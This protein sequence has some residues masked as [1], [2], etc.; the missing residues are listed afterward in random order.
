MSNNIIVW[1]ELWKQQ[2][3]WLFITNREHFKIERKA[4]PIDLINW[5]NASKQITF[6]SSI[7][8]QTFS[9]TSRERLYLSKVLLNRYPIH[10]SGII[11]AQKQRG[12][13]PCQTRDPQISKM[14]ARYKML[15]LASNLC[16]TQFTDYR[17][18]ISDWSLIWCDFWYRIWRVFAKIRLKSKEQNN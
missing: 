7:D 16:F 14:S 8:K 13:I 15:N 5:V 18:V 10:Q 4:I 2:I 3:S 17:I 12:D 9:T 1:F 6:Q 11:C